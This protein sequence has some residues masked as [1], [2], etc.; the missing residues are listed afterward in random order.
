MLATTL[1]VFHLLPKTALKKKKKSQYSCYPHFIDNDEDA[2]IWQGQVS[3][4]GS[5]KD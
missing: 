2:E 4:P 5:H 1:N 3:H